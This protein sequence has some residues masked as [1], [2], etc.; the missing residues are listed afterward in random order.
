MSRRQRGFSTYCRHLERVPL[1]PALAKSFD[2]LMAD[3]QARQEQL[4][5]MM[6]NVSQVLDG[7]EG[8]FASADLATL[9]GAGPYSDGAA[10]TIA[11]YVVRLA[12]GLVQRLPAHARPSSF[13]EAMFTFAFRLTLCSY[14][15]W[16][17]RL[18]EGAGPTL[19]PKKAGNDLIDAYYCASAMYFNGFLTNDERAGMVYT[20]AAHLMRHAFIPAARDSLLR[21]GK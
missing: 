17:N 16:K 6:G 2:G 7:M 3:S 13:A 10:Q 8:T 5:T 18:A 21:P 19:G 11:S 1:H 15:T 20:E 12:A 9:R 14:L 4:R